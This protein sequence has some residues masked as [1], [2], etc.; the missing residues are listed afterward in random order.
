[1]F[2]LYGSITIGEKFNRK[3]QSTSRRKSLSPWWWPHYS[4]EMLAKSFSVKL[5]FCLWRRQLR[6]NH[7]NHSSLYKAIVISL[8]VTHKETELAVTG[9]LLAPAV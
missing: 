9:L 4:L 8:L 3:L 2:Q 5:S 7:Y 6:T 1:M